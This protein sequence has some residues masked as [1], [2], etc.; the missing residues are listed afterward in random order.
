MG[1]DPFRVLLIVDGSGNLV[2]KH[3]C[4]VISADTEV[5][6]VVIYILDPPL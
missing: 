2:L 5:I 1:D 3:P 4:G 6:G